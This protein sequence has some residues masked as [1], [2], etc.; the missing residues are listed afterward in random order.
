MFIPNTPAGTRF[1]CRTRGSTRTR[2]SLLYQ[3]RSIVLGPAAIR[4]EPVVALLNSLITTATYLMAVDHLP[5]ESLRL[6]LIDQVGKARYE[7]GSQLPRTEI[8][9]TTLLGVTEIFDNKIAH[10]PS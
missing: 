2:P 8:P 6:A 7:R 10:G 4:L 1:R 9:W 5:E 3:R